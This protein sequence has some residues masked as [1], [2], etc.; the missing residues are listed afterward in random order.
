MVVRNDYN[1]E[2]V[3]KGKSLI[4]CSIFDIGI[5]KKDSPLR[6]KCHF[7]L[8][9]AYQIGIRDFWTAPGRTKTPDTRFLCDGIPNYHSR[10][11][12]QVSAR[13]I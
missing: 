1:H 7:A 2:N 4:L 8:H 5:L 10:Q 3:F 9:I 11:N 6:A 12:I 13:M